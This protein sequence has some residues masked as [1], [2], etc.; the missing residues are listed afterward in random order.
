LATVMVV[1]KYQG[2]QA[3]GSNPTQHS[4]FITYA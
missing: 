4:S 2:C 3:F 1:Y